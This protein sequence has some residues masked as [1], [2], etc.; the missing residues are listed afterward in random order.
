[1]AR[2]GISDR[3]RS[4]RAAAGW[5][6]TSARSAGT[7]TSPTAVAELE[8]V[9]ALREADPDAPLLADGFSCRTQ[10]EAL[11]GRRARHLA[12]VLAERLSEPTV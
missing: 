7:R 1:M 6:A 4:C 2:N 10:I 8:L 12:E 9:P 3:H 11:S 5:P